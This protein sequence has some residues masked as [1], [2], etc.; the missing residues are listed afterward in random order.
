MVWPS[1][2][3]RQPGWRRNTPCRRKPICLIMNRWWPGRGVRRIDREHHVRPHE[4]RRHQQQAIARELGFL[5]ECGPLLRDVQHVT[6]DAEF[7]AH[8][9]EHGRGAAAGQLAGPVGDILVGAGAADDSPMGESGAYR[10]A[11]DPSGTRI[12]AAWP[13]TPSASLAFGIRHAIKEKP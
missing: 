11:G 9:R 8:T 3:G 13:V 7:R 4:H 5:V 6:A 2:G 1:L 10:H 12:P